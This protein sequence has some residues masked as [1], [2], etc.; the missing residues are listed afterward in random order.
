M[1]VVQA[2]RSVFSCFV[3]FG[4]ITQVRSRSNASSTW[5]RAAV[6]GRAMVASLEPSVGSDTERTKLD[7]NRGGQ[8]AGLPLLMNPKTMGTPSEIVRLYPRAQG[9]SYRR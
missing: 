8:F 3:G 7:S 6:Q 2:R 1:I 4:L 9:T 5:L